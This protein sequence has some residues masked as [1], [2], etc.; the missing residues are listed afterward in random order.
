[1]PHQRQGK[2]GQVGIKATV[3]HPRR[4]CR[5]R[6]VERGLR[7]GRAAARHAFTGGKEFPRPAPPIRVKLPLT[8]RVETR[9]GYFIPSHTRKKK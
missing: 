8:A 3:P 2:K 5:A 6:I 4:K 7:P 1:M 9:C